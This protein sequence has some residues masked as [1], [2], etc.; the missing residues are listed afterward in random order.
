MRKRELKRWMAKV[1]D[2]T[3]SQRRSLLSELAASEHKHASLGVIEGRVSTHTACPHCAGP[4]IVRNGVADGLQR[5]K[6]RACGKTFNALTGTPL[7]RL[8]QKGKWLAQA[9]ILRDGVAIRPAAQR[10][11]V[12]V[13]TA[14][15]WR[16][17]FLTLPETVQAQTLIGIAEADETYFLHSHKGQRQLDRPPRKRGGKAVKRGL[18]KEQVP[19]LVSRDRA[20][21]TANAI[22]PADDKAAIVAALKPILATDAILC[23]DG[24]A[25][26]ASA[27]REMGVT[28]RPVNLSAGRRVVA[29]VYHIQNVNAFDARLKGW[30]LR[31]HGVATRYLSHYLGWFRA[32]DRSQKNTLSPA[33]LLAMAIGSN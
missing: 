1:G 12:N 31:F 16:H 18:S 4:R 7:A 6:C 19:V 24:S 30:I 27:A 9:E 20:G 8:R 2:L 32:L 29:G 23:T 5:Y 21:N 13:K 14:F 10:L 28:H 33:S 11:D 26:L 3:L 25:T 15:R 17:R 22:L